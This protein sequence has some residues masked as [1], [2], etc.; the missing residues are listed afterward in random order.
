MRRIVLLAGVLLAL[1]FQGLAFAGG[2]VRWEKDGVVI[3]WGTADL[4]WQG[5]TMVPDGRG[6]V[7]IA[8]ADTRGSHES[9]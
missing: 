2:Q 4:G 8:W 7:I 1:L 5:V 6:G 9:I 3:A